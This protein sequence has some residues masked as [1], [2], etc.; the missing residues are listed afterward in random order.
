MFSPKMIPIYMYLCMGQNR[1]LYIILLSTIFLLLSQLSRLLLLAPSRR[2]SRFSSSC[3][4]TTALCTTVRFHACQGGLTATFNGWSHTATTGFPRSRLRRSFLCFFLPQCI[5]WW[6][7]RN[8]ALSIFLFLGRSFTASIFLFLGRFLSGRF[9]QDLAHFILFHMGSL[10][11]ISIIGG[12]FYH[13]GR[14]LIHNMD[15]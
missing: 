5:S 8:I 2:W 10:T 15:S 1:S 3:W 13:A 6:C 4:L 11:F 9:L 14:I 7:G 12:C